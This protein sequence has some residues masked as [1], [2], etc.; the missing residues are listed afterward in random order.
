MERI[1]SHGSPRSCFSAGITHRFDRSVIAPEQLA[2]YDEIVQLANQPEADAPLLIDV[3]E[4]AELEAT[5]RIP[6][7]IN[8]PVGQVKTELELPA[9]VF[10]AKY[11]RRKPSPTDAIIFCCR[12]GVRSGNAAHEA[13]QMGFKRV[14]NYVGS[15]LDKF[16]PGCIEPRLVATL[17]E[18]EDLPNHPEVLLIDVR[19]P[20]E[21]EATGRIP[22]SINIPL[23]T[24]QHELGLGAEAFE[25][26]YGRKKPTLDDPLIF[27]CRSGVRAGQ[28]ALQADQL[29]Y[30]KYESVKNYVG[31]WL[32]YGPKHD[33]ARFSNIVPVLLR[34]VS[35]RSKMSSAIATYE[36]VL[37][38]PNHPEKL[39]IDVRNPDELAETG[40]IPTSINIPLDQVKQAFGPETEADQFRKLYGVA[41]PEPDH[42]LILSCRTGRR[43]QMALDTITELG[44]RKAVPQLEEGMK[45]AE[46]EFKARYGREKPATGT[47]I[48]FHCK[49]GGRAQKATDLATSLGYTNA[50]NYKGSWTEWAAKQ[51]EA[52]K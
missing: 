44:Y 25:A 3:R 34:C 20:A 6:T 10:Q 51:Q 45:L 39:L 8:I 37:D 35:S 49:M 29:G 13:E 52:A 31:S 15:W 48:I 32:E 50:R 4:P 21:L 38:L 23:K 36:E 16:A 28:A 17:A 24:V 18:V 27:S 19:E 26:K 41:K 33:P 9:T 12:I 11:G 42:Y 43:S 5:G 22:T 46:S 7:S 47:E 30:R 14:K 2:T 1:G 40:K